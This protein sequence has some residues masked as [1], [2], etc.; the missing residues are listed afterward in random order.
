MIVGNMQ[1][2]LSFSYWKGEDADSAAL[3]SRVPRLRN[4]NLS[5]NFESVVHKQRSSTSPPATTRTYLVALCDLT[6]YP[7][8]ERQ[9]RNYD[10]SN[11]KRA[12][13]LRATL[14]V[15]ILSYSFG[16]ATVPSRRRFTIAFLPTES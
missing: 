15:F 16:T 8:P 4:N 6:F 3:A 1:D 10:Y 11:I 12:Q 5:L 9:Q 13:R 14:E 2:A 7:P